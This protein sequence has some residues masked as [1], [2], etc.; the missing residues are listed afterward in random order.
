MSLD[1]LTLFPQFAFVFRTLSYNL[2]YRVRGIYFIIG[3]SSSSSG[4]S[5]SGSNFLGINSTNICMPI[6]VNY[7]KQTE[8]CTDTYCQVDLV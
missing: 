5:Y 4:S 3:S 1:I 6:L 7:G 2:Y 8:A